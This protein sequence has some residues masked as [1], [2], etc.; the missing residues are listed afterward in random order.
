MLDNETKKYWLSLPVIRE[1]QTDN[2][3]SEDMI[4]RVWVSRVEEDSS[5]FPIVTVEHNIKGSW[6][7]IATI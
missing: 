6:Q 3:V 7:T 4:T 5:G 2:L 1:G